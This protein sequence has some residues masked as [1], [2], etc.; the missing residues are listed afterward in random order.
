MCIGLIFF[1]FNMKRIIISTL[2]L[3]LG[4]SIFAQEN[5]KLRIAQPLN[6]V[7]KEFP[8]LKVKVDDD[9]DKYLFQEFDYVH[10]YYY[11][12]KKDLCYIQVY[13]YHI[14]FTSTLLKN[15]NTEEYIKLSAS[16]YLRVDGGGV[17][18]FTLVVNEK[19]KV[20]SLI[21]EKE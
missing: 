13:V 9:G 15:M 2:I 3:F 10:I 4:F 7:R 16:E 21:A 8:T 14:S 11:F 6:E 5:I 18:K 17:I 1:T 19:R 20:V 12:D